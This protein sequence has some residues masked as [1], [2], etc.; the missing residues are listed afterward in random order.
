MQAHSSHRLGQQSAPGRHR[1]GFTLIELLVV[2]A[3]VL[4][5]AALLLPA[6][7]NARESAQTAK[8]AQNL[9]QIGIA[10]RLYGDDYGDFIVPA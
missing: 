9:R 10:C 7:R 8:C 3:I 5:L 4:L 6:L 2:V 1:R